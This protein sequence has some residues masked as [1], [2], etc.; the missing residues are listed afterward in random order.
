MLRISS[1]VSIPDNEWEIHAIRSQGAGGQNVNKVAT[2]IQLFFDIRASSL[3][4][5]YK[6]RLLALSDHRITEA[7]VVII[8][9]QEHRSQEK[10]REAALTRLQQIVRSAGV[11]ER[12]RKP[13]RPTRSS[14]RKRLQ[15]KTE[16][17]QTKAL[18]GKIEP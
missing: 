2:A 3:P 8:K 14:Q 12:P 17:S 9:S 4:D 7:G 18:R 13:T 1:K 10:N 6:E 16:R 11:R 15:K 5:Y